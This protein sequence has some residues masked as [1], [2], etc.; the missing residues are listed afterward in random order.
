MPTNQDRELIVVPKYP[1]RPWIHEIDVLNK[2]R[3]RK[4]LRE[5]SKK[6]YDVVNFTT[7]VD[8]DAR[9]KLRTEKKVRVIYIVDID[10]P[11]VQTALSMA[12]L[13]QEYGIPCTFNPRFYHFKDEER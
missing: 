12:E 13:N 6:R 11:F 7:A 1:Y 5:L 2:A 3:Y 4:E 8:L 10:D 9:G